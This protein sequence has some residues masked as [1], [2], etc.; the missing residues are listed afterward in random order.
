MKTNWGLGKMKG[1]L[2][3]SDYIIYAVG[4]YVEVFIYAYVFYWNVSVAMA[5]GCLGFMKCRQGMVGLTNRRKQETLEDFSQFLDA[6]NIMLTSGKSIE[7]SF[8]IAYGEMMENQVKEGIFLRGIRELVTGLHGGLNSEEVL[9]AFSVTLDIEIIHDFVKG[10]EVSYRKGG[11][12]NKLIM[13]TS[14]I[15]RDKLDTTIEID[16][17]LSGKRYEIKIM[18]LMPLIMIIMLNKLVPEYMIPNY[19]TA[20]GRVVMSCSALLIVGSNLLVDRI[21][22]VIFE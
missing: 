21:G 15:I 3:K 11:N 9:K 7:N 6:I 20:L 10:F 17:L 2:K 13:I 12:I 22:K 16:A 5:M 8:E 4:S 14:G 1:Y 18:K 19:S